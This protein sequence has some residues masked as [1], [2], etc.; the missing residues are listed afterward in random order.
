MIYIYIFTIALIKNST[1]ET[2]R[3]ATVK[4]AR[5]FNINF[6]LLCKSNLLLTKYTN[7][8]NI[9]IIIQKLLALSSHE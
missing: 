1:T 5:L 7:H 9:Y 2:K 6:N 8:T 4:F 3:K